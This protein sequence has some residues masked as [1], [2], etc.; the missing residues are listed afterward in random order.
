MSLRDVRTGDRQF[1]TERL[2]SRELTTGQF[3]CARVVP[4]GSELQFY[5]G[6]EP[7]HPSQRHHLIDMLDNYVEPED[8]VDF[9]SA[10]F[11]PPTLSSREGDPIVLCEAQ[12]ELGELNGIRRK[13]SRA[14][15]AAD[16][17]RWH[18]RDGE[19]ILGI[20]TLDG[21]KLSVE[22]MTETRFDQIVDAVTSMHPM[23]SAVH[24][25]RAPAADHMAQASKRAG[26]GRVEQDVKIEQDP[27]IASIL[28]KRIR[29]HEASWI[30]GKIPALDGYTPTQAAADPTRREDLI[31]LLDSFPET[32]Q[33]GAMSP[34]RLR[35]ALGLDDGSAF[36][37]AQR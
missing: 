35:E 15:G 29:E 9:L 20:M 22:A 12:F 5:G 1:V 2:A 28:E 3:V 8:L 33:S 31:R 21:T 10:R 14:Y 16:G 37:R 11:A 23:L 32:G 13:L 19:S 27:E 17:N 30:H 25:T 7:V 36:W 26:S 18:W 34:R 6:I 24:E 4:V